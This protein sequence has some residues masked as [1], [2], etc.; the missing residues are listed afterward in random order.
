[1][2]KKKSM[3]NP[4]FLF[5]RSS[6]FLTGSNGQVIGHYLDNYCTQNNK[7]RKSSSKNKKRKSLKQEKL[8]KK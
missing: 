6:F 1:M 7:K 8:T 3:N 5:K 4:I 2:Q